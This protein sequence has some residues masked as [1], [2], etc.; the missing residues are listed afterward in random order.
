MFLHVASWATGRLNSDL[1]SPKDGCILSQKMTAALPLPLKHPL[2]VRMPPLHL[3]Q[4]EE[5]Q[6]ALLGLSSP[7]LGFSPIHVR[8]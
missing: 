3:V 8:G 1:P 4:A 6:E 2:A 5:K 7:D